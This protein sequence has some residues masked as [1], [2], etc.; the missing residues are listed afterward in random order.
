MISHKIKLE[1]VKEYYKPQIVGNVVVVN[2]KCKVKEGT[3]L[4]KVF[5]IAKWNSSSGI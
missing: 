1:E 5:F 3:L 4:K 2:D